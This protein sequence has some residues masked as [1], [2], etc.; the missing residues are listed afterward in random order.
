MAGYYDSYDGDITN[1][2]LSGYNYRVVKLT[3]DPVGINTPLAN[4]FS[5]SPNTITANITIESNQVFASNTQIIIS[6]VLGREVVKI[7][8]SAISKRININLSE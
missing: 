7:T 6:D 4:N 8:N 1:T 5:V 3:S 2:K